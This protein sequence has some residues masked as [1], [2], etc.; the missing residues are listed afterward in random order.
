MSTILDRDNLLILHFI[1]AIPAYNF[2]VQR[3][4]DGQAANPKNIHLRG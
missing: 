4:S 1:V 2:L 3:R